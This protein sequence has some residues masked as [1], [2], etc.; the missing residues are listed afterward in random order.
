MTTHQAQPEAP[1]EP[2]TLDDH[3]ALVQQVED[4]ADEI[5]EG[6]DDDIMSSYLDEWAEADPHLARWLA[7]DVQPDYMRDGYIGE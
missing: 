1:P 7:Y 4:A 3:D 6:E 2:A 5:A